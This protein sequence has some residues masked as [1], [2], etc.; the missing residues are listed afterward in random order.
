VLARVSACVW[1]AAHW[2]S[3]FCCDNEFG[4]ITGFGDKRTGD[5]LASAG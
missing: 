4:A 5:L 2:I 3:N 1:F